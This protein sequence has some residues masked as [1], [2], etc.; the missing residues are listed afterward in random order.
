MNK[1]VIFY[2]IAAIAALG[3]VG[4]IVLQVIRPDASATLI[5]FVFTLLPVL[6][7]F[8]GLAAMQAQQNREIE[9]IKK[10]TNGTLSRKDD[11]IA[12]YRAVIAEHAPDALR[13]IETNA[14]PIVT[15]AQLR[16]DREAAGDAS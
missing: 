8:G 13:A 7:G 14:V 15:R 1:Q 4:V 9:T 10:N 6:A 16:E 5:N 3:V 11:E 2:I 12:T